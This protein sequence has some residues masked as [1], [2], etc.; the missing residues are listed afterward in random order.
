MRI[1]INGLGRIGRTLLRILW[2]RGRHE[3][4]HVNDLNPDVA[5][6]AYLIRY[7]SNYGRADASVEP[8]QGCLTMER[9]SRRWTIACTAASDTR[10]V[11]WASSGVDVVI[12]AT[13]TEINNIGC[14]DNISD[15]V[16]HSIVTHTHADAD[17]TVVFGVNEDAL[18]PSVHRVIST[19]I[20][21]AN[22]LAPVVKAVHAL[23]GIDHAFVTTLHPWLSYQNLVDGP[24]RFRARPGQFYPDYALG[25]ASPGALIPKTTTAGP[26][27]EA[28]IPELAGHITSSSYRVPTSAVCYGDITAVLSRP[29][30]VEEVLF[31]LE[32]LSP[33]SRLSNEALVS[34]DL[35]GESTS[36]TIDTRW[37]TVN[38]DR[39]LKC[40]V[41]YDNEWG[42]CSRVV[43]VLDRIEESIEKPRASK[44]ATDLSS[45]AS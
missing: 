11:G 36:G 34:T 8:Q 45:S 23:C 15:V 44:T 33:Y 18:D 6:L 4:V 14:R 30:C 42:Y 1:G 27:I 37:L 29:S 25:R 2:Q 21:D 24:V 41:G 16:G 26:A 10:H 32:E 19:S 7:D 31:A 13:G 12:E 22:A 3:V 9:E 39:Y 28:L 20:C 35:I 17:A 43:D 5:N 38:E 40:M